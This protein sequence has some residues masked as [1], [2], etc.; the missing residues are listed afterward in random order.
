MRASSR[1]LRLRNSLTYL[2]TYSIGE[3]IDHD[4]LY[5]LHFVCC[6][7]CILQATI[8]PL[9]I[10]L[11]F[12]VAR[13]FDNVLLVVLTLFTHLHVAI[14]HPQFLGDRL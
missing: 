2:L 8:L 13:K 14:V 7:L 3:L 1:F 12:S 4:A 5:V 10:L 6:I 9:F 11:H